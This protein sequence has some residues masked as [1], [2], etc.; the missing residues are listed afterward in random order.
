MKRILFLAI[1]TITMA[2]SVAQKR[3]FTIAD[4]YR[5]RSVY[6]VTLSPDGKT[7][8]YTANKSDLK[9][10][11][12]SSDIYMMDADGKNVKAVTTD[13]KSSGATWSK[14]GKSLFFSSSLSGQQ[15]IYRYYSDKGTAEKLTD[16][17]LE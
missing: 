12:S 9:A 17:E 15:Q 3:A 6:G 16:F 1:A 14:D 11:K 2:T 8:A 13:G 7:I 5:V 10:S 4:L